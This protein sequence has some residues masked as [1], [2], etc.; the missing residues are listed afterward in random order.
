MNAYRSI[1]VKGSIVTV[2]GTL[3]FWVATGSSK[4]VAISKLSLVSE[5]NN[6]ESSKYL[7]VAENVILCRKYNGGPQH[8]Y[9]NRLPSSWSGSRSLPSPVVSLN[10]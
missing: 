3:G 10:R 7:G 6:N 9:Y 8:R 1:L 2:L 4:A 5:V